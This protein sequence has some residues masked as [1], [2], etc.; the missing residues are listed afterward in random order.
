MALPALALDAEGRLPPRPPPAPLA[1]A[2]GV[3]DRAQ[4]QEE[5]EE[6]VGANA[7]GGCRVDG[8]SHDG[9]GGGDVEAGAGDDPLENEEPERCVDMFLWLKIMMKCFKEEQVIKIG[10]R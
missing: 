7:G 3:K 8:S 5:R 10:N 9:N 1:S 6:K 2:T 4:R